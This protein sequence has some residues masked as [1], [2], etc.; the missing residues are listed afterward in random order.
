[1]GYIDSA[2]FGYRETRPIQPFEEPPITKQCRRCNA[3]F[4]TRSRIRKRCDTCQTVVAAE[5]Q[6]KANDKQKKKRLARRA[7]LAV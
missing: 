5:K 6:Q 1:M 7:A 2:I 4:I 3:E